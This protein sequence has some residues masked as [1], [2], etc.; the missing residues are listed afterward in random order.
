MQDLLREMKWRSGL[1]SF[2]IQQIGARKQRHEHGSII[3]REVGST[4]GV[5]S[6][7]ATSG[8]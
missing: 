6:L 7:R 3:R 2:H 5:Y 1:S 8:W 4:S